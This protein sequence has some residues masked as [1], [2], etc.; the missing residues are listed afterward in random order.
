[1]AVLP[2]CLSPIISS[3]W[4]RPIGV[5]ASIAVKPVWSGWWT[6]LRATIPGATLS[7]ARDLSVIISPLPSIGRPVGLTIR[8]IR[9]SPTGTEA[10]LP[11]VLTTIPSLIWVYSPK[12]TT[13]TLSSSRFN[14]IPKVPLPSSNSTSSFDITFL[15]P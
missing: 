8:P 4:P 2:V 3:R 9:A 12:I 15:N 11:V 13:P 6:D 10:I 7:I 1:M 14:V 5:K